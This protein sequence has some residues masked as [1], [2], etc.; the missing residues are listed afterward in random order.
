[1]FVKPEVQT[2]TQV[3]VLLRFWRRKICVKRIRHCSD[4]V[5]IKPPPPPPPPPPPLVFGQCR[6]ENIYGLLCL[7][8]ISLLTIDPFSAKGSSIHKAWR[9]TRTLGQLQNT[10]ASSNPIVILVF[11]CVATWQVFVWQPCWFWVYQL[12]CHFE[13]RRTINSVPQSI[14]WCKIMKIWFNDNIQFI[15]LSHCW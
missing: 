13:W 11:L 1:M 5:C 6:K 10:P 7:Y 15:E 3:I 12:P 14:A 4:L 9:I 8:Q 2:A